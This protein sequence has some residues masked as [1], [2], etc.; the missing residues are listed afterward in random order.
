MSILELHGAFWVR[1]SASIKSGASVQENC[2]MPSSICCNDN[3]QPAAQVNS[4]DELFFPAYNSPMIKRPV[5]R[6]ALYSDRILALKPR[7][8]VW[9]AGARMASIK[10]ISS[11]LGKLTGRQFSNRSEKDGVIVYREK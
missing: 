5:G 8:S 2:V 10:A 11:R 7:K 6:P 9:L 3:N 1:A 4:V